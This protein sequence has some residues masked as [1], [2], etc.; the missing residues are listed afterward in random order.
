[1]LTSIPIA[2]SPAKLQINMEQGFSRRPASSGGKR[3]LQL[4]LRKTDVSA[5]R[6]CSYHSFLFFQHRGTTSMSVDLV[7]AVDNT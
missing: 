5:V 1:M 3:T 2:D 7:L 6:T 4:Q